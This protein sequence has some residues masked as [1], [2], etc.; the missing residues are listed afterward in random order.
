MKYVIQRANADTFE[1]EWLVWVC[2]S[3]NGQRRECWTMDAARAAEFSASDA[4]FVHAIVGGVIARRPELVDAAAG[5]V[6]SL[7]RRGLW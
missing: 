4:Q 5:C 2:V 6:A 1:C 7:E 3:P